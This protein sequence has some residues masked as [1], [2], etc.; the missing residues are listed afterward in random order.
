[1]VEAQREVS[2]RAHH[3]GVVHHDRPLLDR[4]DPEDGHLRLVDDREAELSA[5]LSRVGDREGS[6]VDIVRAQFLRSGPVG[7][8][9]DLAS[10]CTHALLV[11]LTDDGHDQARVEC[12]RHA[13]VDPFP[14]H[15]RV[16]IERGIHHR[17]A[18]KGI[19]NGL[20]D[21]GQIREA[22]AFT[23]VLRPLLLA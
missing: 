17:M 21:E 8:I 18:P 10:E 14:E 11:R 22:H 9:G 13:E 1:V 3:H 4:P 20:R 12:D 19:G 16:A 2:H 15:H 5:E 7:Q 6:A 23:L